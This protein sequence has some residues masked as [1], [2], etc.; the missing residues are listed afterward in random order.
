MTGTVPGEPRPLIGSERLWRIA[1]QPVQA[2]Q[3]IARELAQRRNARHGHLPTGLAQQPRRDQA[4]SPVVALPAHHSNLA[5][6]CDALD[7]PR[8]A[9][10]RAL[11]QLQ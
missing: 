2:L 9:G 11:H 7:C 5:V 8:D 4:V 6:G 3:C 1:V 10:S